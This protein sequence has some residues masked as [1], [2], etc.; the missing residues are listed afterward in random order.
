MKQLETKQSGA[1]VSFR[2]DLYSQRSTQ[3]L[4][5]PF[6]KRH[7][8]FS[9][10]SNHKIATSSFFYW[11]SVS[12]TFQYSIFKSCY[13]TINSLFWLSSIKW[14]PFQGP[15][16]PH[17][18]CKTIIFFLLHWLSR[19]QQRPLQ[20]PHHPPIDFKA[21]LSSLT[22][23]IQDLVVSFPRTTPPTLGLFSKPIFFALTKSYSSFPKTDFPALSGVLSKV[24]I[25]IHRS[26]IEVHLLLMLNS[27]EQFFQPIAKGNLQEYF[28][29]ASFPSS[30]VCE[31]DIKAY[32][33]SMLL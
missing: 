12:V 10:H 18:D 6:V 16:Q 33:S 23:A 28:T 27:K 19:T 20:G 1:A 15:H 4:I 11:L 24:H 14:C 29:E 25:A 31:T 2:L 3:P 9:S 26:F 30:L 17:I 22:L 13:Y 5:G 21:M 32:F 7:S 8:L